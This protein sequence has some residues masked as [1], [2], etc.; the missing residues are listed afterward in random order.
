M[1]SRERSLTVGE[2][3]DQYNPEVQ[4]GAF[5]QETSLHRCQGDYLCDG[6]VGANI[7]WLRVEPVWIAEMPPSTEVRHSK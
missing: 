7:R 4:L 6:T 5:E 2:A 1:T 3:V